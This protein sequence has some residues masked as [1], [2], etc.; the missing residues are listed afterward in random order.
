MSQAINNQTY[1]KPIIIER[2]EYRV[3]EGLFGILR[4]HRKVNATKIGDTLE[5][6]TDIEPSEVYLNGRLLK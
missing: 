2:V 5:I 1:I 3:E 6:I 4:W